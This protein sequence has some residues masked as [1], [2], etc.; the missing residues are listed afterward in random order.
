M[1]YWIEFPRRA[2]VIHT[3]A[4]SFQIVLERM[5][6]FKAFTQNGGIRKTET[7]RSPARLFAQDYKC[8]QSCSDDTEVL[9][10]FLEAW[11]PSLLPSSCR[12]TLIRTTGVVE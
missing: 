9:N 2:F 5:I 6:H 1:M 3:Y 8:I 10:F 4:V 7:P 12:D 11:I